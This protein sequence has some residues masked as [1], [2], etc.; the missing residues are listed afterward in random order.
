[1]MSMKPSV[2]VT[3]FGVGHYHYV[4]ITESMLERVSQLRCCRLRD[5]YLDLDGLLHTCDADG[6]MFYK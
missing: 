1:M 6:I 5:R 2:A 3:E 4:H